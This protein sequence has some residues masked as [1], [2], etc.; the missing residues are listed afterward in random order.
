MGNVFFPLSI[1]YF[2]NQR[3]VNVRSELSTVNS[4]KIQEN[5]VF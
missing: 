3:F 2:M 1:F 5:N 4:L